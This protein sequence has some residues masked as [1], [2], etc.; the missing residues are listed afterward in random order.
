M[1]NGVISTILLALSLAFSACSGEDIWKQERLNQALI[2]AV[3]QGNLSSVDSCIRAGANIESRTMDGATPLIMAG[4]MGNQPILKR[5]IDAGAEIDAKRFGYYASTALMEAAVRNDTLVAALLLQSGADI[6]LRDTFGDPA[7]NWGAYYGHEVYVALLLDNGADWKTESKH[8]NALDIA[9]KEWNLDVCQF[10]ISQ[11]AGESLPTS[12]KAL[13]E[14]AWSNDINACYQL[15]EEGASPSQKD[16]LGMPV[17]TWATAL[18]FDSMVNVLIKN[19]ADVNATNRAGQTALA[20]AARFGHT[21]ILQT[22]LKAEADPNLA[23]SRYR[24][25]PLMAATIGGH[26][27]IANSL[28][29]NGADI[30]TQDALVGYSPLMYAVAYGYPDMVSLLIEKR[31]NPYL[32]GLDGTGLYDLLGYSKDERIAKMLEAYVLERQ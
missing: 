31:A 28:L 32:K 7:L 2:E 25:T 19:G 8:G 15:L 21:D 26:V 24:L 13:V 16:E 30:D 23:G 1:N 14:A 17:L 12:E 5:L 6:H 18:G 3:G 9:T 4:E 11:G 10:L 29:E 22:L 20:A 27:D